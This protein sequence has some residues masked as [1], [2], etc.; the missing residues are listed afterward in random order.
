MVGEEVEEVTNIKGNGK[1][2]ERVGYSWLQVVATLVAGEPSRLAVS[3][4]L[5]LSHSLLA[6]YWAPHF[7]ISAYSLW[8]LLFSRR[9]QPIGFIILL[10]FNLFSS[11]YCPYAFCYPAAYYY[12]RKGKAG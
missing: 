1:L 6:L 12:M 9:S 8:P 11:R 10:K 3:V 2:G 7:L 5:F 4:T